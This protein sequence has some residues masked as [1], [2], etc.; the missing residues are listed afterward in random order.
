VR[1]VVVAFAESLVGG[2]EQSAIREEPQRTESPG[3][4]TASERLDLAANVTMR[5]KSG[6]GGLGGYKRRHAACCTRTV[7]DE[8]QKIDSPDYAACGTSR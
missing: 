2:I 6:P 3:A 4:T 8:V 5:C 7:G 1:R